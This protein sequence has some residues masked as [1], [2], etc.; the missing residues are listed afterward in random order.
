MFYN[1]LKPQCTAGKLLSLVARPV[2][3]NKPELY[4]GSKIKLEFNIHYH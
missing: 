2:I 3:L 1:E 4:Y